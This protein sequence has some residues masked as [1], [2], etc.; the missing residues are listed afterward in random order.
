MA[1]LPLPSKKLTDV[2]A[3]IDAGDID[4]VQ[5]GKPYVLQPDS[6]AANKPYVLLR[7]ALR[8]TGRVGVTKIALRTRESLAMLRVHDQVLVLQTM[9]W[10]DEVRDPAG[11]APPD[12]V[13]VRPQEV[14]MA[15]SLMEKLSEGFDLEGLEDEYH[16]ALRDLVMSKVEVR[17][18]GTGRTS[19]APVPAD[20]VDLMAALQASI[21]QAEEGGTAPPAA[22]APP[23]KKTGTAAKAVGGKAGAK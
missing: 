5:L 15:S 18:A 13:T 8:Q 17:P 2:L 11:R 3:F 14:R 12:S 23:G 7:E 10:P 9:L 21:N 4:P 16:Q 20:V 22:D 6:S 19:R 1:Q